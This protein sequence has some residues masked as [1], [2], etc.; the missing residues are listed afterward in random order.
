VPNVV[1]VDFAVR[2]NI[3]ATVRDVADSLLGEVRDEHGARPTATTAPSPTTTAP[4]TAPPTTTAPTPVD[5][6]PVASEITTLTGGNP[7]QFCPA[8][9][10][11]APVISAWA[12]ATVGALPAEEGLADLV[13]GPALRRAMEAYVSSAPV[14]L[15]TRAQPLLD[16][17]TTATATLQTLGL[18]DAAVAALAD[19]ITQAVSVPDAPDGISL[20]TTTV[21]GLA[22]R[23]G[24]S[25]LD[26]AAAAFVTSQADATNTFDL[27]Y[28]PG[29]V[30]AAAGFTCDAV[31]LG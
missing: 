19:Q 12:Y 18:D 6:L 28:V 26:A 11:A 8:L 22:D 20:Q 2:G 16:R 17:A 27:G 10:A 5:T 7:A 21:A 25:R 30:A 3:T 15:A 14:E 13:Y 9:A 29:D 23:V 31:S 1:A 4:T 24:A